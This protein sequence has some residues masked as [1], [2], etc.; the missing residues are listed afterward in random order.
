[1]P[2]LLIRPTRRLILAGGAALTAAPTLLPRPALA[3]VPASGRLSFE[4]WR[5]GKK[6]GH[7]LVTFQTNGEEVTARS[8]VDLTLTLGPIT[9]YRYAWRCTEHWRGAKFLGLEAH[10]SANGEMLKV[11]AQSAPNGVRIDATKLGSVLLPANA[12]P[13]AHWNPDAIHPPFF[14]P[15]DGKTL[16]LAASRRADTYTPTGGRPVAATKISLTGETQID[17]WYT[18]AGVWIGL[19]G[20]IKDGS[21]LDYRR[22]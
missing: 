7:H 1:M 4:I 16:K 14:N 12:V 22:I 6:V 5:Q 2:D 9:L 10:T 13:L 19:R 21:M 17:D 15:Q 3:A 18:P 20:K 11:V 8:D